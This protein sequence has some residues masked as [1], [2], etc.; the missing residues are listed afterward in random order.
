MKRTCRKLSEE[1]KLK[2]SMAMKGRA[3]TEKHK[4]ALSRSLKAYWETI[5]KENNDLPIMNND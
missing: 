4:E 2:I 3:K 5:P 1:T